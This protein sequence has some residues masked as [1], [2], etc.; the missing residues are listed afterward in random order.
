MS[1]SRYTIQPQSFQKINSQLLYISIS[2]YEGDWQSI[3]HTHHFAELIYVVGGQGDFRSG[4]RKQPVSAGDLIIVS[5]NV[6][7][8]EVSYPADPLEY[9][10]L[11]IDGVTFQNTGNEEGSSIYNYKK[12]NAVLSLLH[13]LLAEAEEEREGCSLACQN[14]LEVLLIHIL[15]MQ[16]LVPFPYT[17]TKMTKECGLIKRYLD[18][19]YADTITLESLASLA[20]M[21]KYYLVHAFTKYTGLSPI[22]YLNTRRL[23]VSRELLSA[24]NHSI[25]QVASL[26]G[27]SSQSY[28]TQAFKKESGISPSQYRRFGGK[29]LSQ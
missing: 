6:E 5:P 7:H 14:L 4:N 18:S 29:A 20:H 15:R 25:S 19:N 1:N 22:N 28:F 26:S 9:F 21:N 13:L 12:D 8:T 11:G 2:R 16:K 10:V 24:T 23:Q 27:F 17:A 3:P